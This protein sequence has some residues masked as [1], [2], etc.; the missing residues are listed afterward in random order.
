MLRLKEDA[1]AWLAPMCSSFV[2]ACFS[3]SFFVCKIQV[4]CMCKSASFLFHFIQNNEYLVLR[5]GL[6][7]TSFLGGAF[8]VKGSA[9]SG[10]KAMLQRHSS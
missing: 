10:Q 9:I 3:V 1:L 5:L 2:P 6:L 7:T 8:C 4:C